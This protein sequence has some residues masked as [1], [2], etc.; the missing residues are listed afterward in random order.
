MKADSYKI[1]LVD[2]DPDIRSFLGY[3]IKR[4]GYQYLTCSNGFDA[5]DIARNEL[6]HLII[7]DVM[8][9]EMDGFQTCHELK[10]IPEL[11]SSII[12]FLT[13]RNEDYSRNTGFFVGADDY[14]TKPISPRILINRIEKLVK[15]YELL[16]NG[17]KSV[18]QKIH[19][20]IIID[21]E[22]CIAIKDNVK[23]ILPEKEFDLLSLLISNPNKIIRR[24]E[25]Y[26]SIW[27]HDEIKNVKQQTIDRLIQNLRKKLGQK[28]IQIIEDGSYIYQ[29]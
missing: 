17:E 8:M 13:A 18:N 26:L 12:V 14:I 15:R 5:I 25:I 2:D 7:L 23:H 22:N 1:L 29:Y 6:P 10:K 24:E 28:N 9:P 11:N 16:E 3:N 21:K 27:N 4:S 19:A 20:D